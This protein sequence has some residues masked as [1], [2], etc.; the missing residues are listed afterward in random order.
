LF[1][2]YAL[3]I[4]AVLD[5]ADRTNGRKEYLD[6]ISKLF[7]GQN[8]TGIWD[9]EWYDDMNWMAIALLRASLWF[10]NINGTLSE[11]FM[12]RSKWLYQKI[13]GGW[14]TTCCG[15]KKGG[16][17]WDKSHTSKA[18]ASNGGPVILSSMLY[19]ITLD[20]SYLDFAKKVF[21]FWNDNMVIQNSGHVCDHIQSDGTTNCDW[22]C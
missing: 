22:Y 12:Y 19:K 6:W 2:R 16:I 7:N 17:W 5:A 13:E 1:Y 11:E 9:R 15:S 18:T 14:D 21:T 3:A 4:D 20:S 10:K 8:K